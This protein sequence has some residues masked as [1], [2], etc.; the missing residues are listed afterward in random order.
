[1][2]CALA[3]AA[4]SACAPGSGAVAGHAASLSPV[5]SSAPDPADNGTDGEAAYLATEPGAAVFI[6]WTDD[7][8]RLDASLDVSQLASGA[9]GGVQGRQLNA[10]GTLQ[11][12][13]VDL[14]VG[15]D[16]E[17][18]GTVSGHTLTL[19]IPQPD[20][21]LQAVTFTQATIG[22]YNTAVSQLHQQVQADAAAASSAAQ[23]AAATRAVTRAEATVAQDLDNL[24]A[25]T[26]HLRSDA[27]FTADLTQMGEDLAAEQHD[28]ALERADVAPDNCGTVDGDDGTVDGDDGT[29]QGD[30][31]STQGDIA[32]VQ[33]DIDAVSRQLSQIA[34]DVAALNSAIANDPG[35]TATNPQDQVAAA[36]QAGSAAIAAAKAAIA[37]A[38]TQVAAYLVQDQQ[39]LGQANSIANNCGE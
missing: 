31:G 38:N 25:A 22:D 19:H 7:H 3:T 28:L 26:G 9:D 14:D 35:T 6:R 12:H 27:D 29:L 4:L 18:T 2:S 16:G 13:S 39:L 32:S 33:A 8:G 37:K 24:A 17:W 36:T 23:Q 1:M 34:G 10:T 5:G 11:G 21:S 20:G 15:G 30:E